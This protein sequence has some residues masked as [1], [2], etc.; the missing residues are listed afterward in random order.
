M[1]AWAGML[2]PNLPL[3]TLCPPMPC[4]E[5]R[6][7]GPAG[8]LQARAGSHR[9]GVLPLLLLH[10]SGSHCWCGLVL[11]VCVCVCAWAGCL[12]VMWNPGMKEQGGKRGRRGPCGSVYAPG[13]GAIRLSLAGV[14]VLW[15]AMCKGD[16][17]CGGEEGSAVWWDTHSCPSKVP[18][19]QRPAP[20]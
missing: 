8:R 1:Q 10:R 15:G 18:A 7:P 13:L 9:G 6:Q 11:G 12:F 5:I 17:A 19:L 3:L 14:A 2:M 4:R 20:C 16:R